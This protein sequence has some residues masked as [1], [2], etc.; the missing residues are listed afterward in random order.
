MTFAKLWAAIKT[1]WTSEPFAILIPFAAAVFWFFTHGHDWKH[2]IHSLPTWQEFVTLCALWTVAAGRFFAFFGIKFDSTT[3]PKVGLVLLGFLALGSTG[4]AHIQAIDHDVISCVDKTLP[5]A[6]QDIE[7]EAAPF[8]ADMLLC[9]GATGFDPSAIPAC[10]AQAF[11]SVDAPL[12]ADA[13]A[14]KLCVV[15][16]IEN[17]PNALAERKARA[18]EMRAKLVRASN[19]R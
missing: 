1:A 4:C 2:P 9:D 13:A 16:T 5:Q 11:A 8:L 7:S 17:D 6:K 15:Q 10:A 3:P 19:G 12:G 18:A 14:F